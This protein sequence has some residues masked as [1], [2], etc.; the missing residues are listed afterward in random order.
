MLGAAHP[1]VG[2]ACAVEVGGNALRQ[3]GH[4]VEMAGHQGPG[5]KE[6]RDPGEAG[7]FHDQNKKGR[8]LQ[9]AGRG[10]E[11]IPDKTMVNQNS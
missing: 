9:E 2:T 1:P 10:E 7:T 8:N 3:E 11:T 4:P 5:G 6:E